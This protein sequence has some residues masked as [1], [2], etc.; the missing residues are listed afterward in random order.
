MNWIHY[1]IFVKI[2][3]F[4]WGKKFSVPLTLKTY[5]ILQ[6]GKRYGNMETNFKERVD[7]TE[8]RVSCTINEQAKQI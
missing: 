5:E 4:Y 2:T 6:D 8:Q 7:S 1:G 3:G